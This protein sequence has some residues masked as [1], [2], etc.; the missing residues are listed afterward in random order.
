MRKWEYI[1]YFY[2]TLPKKRDLNEYGEDGSE[3]VVIIEDESEVAGSGFRLY[4]KRP[5]E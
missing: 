1:D 3:L 4:L 5:V 2:S